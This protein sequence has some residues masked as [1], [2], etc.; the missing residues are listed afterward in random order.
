MVPGLAGK[1][2]EVAVAAAGPV[3]SSAEAVRLGREDL[4]T[5]E[6]LAALV[7][8]L[9]LM[10]TLRSAALAL[11]PMAIGVVSVSATLGVLGALTSVMPVSVFAVNVAA[12]LGF[13]LSVDY[14]LL[15]MMRCREE[16]AGGT[17]VGEAV[18]RSVRSAGRAVLFSAAT[19]VARMAALLIFPVPFLRSLA[20]GGIAVVVFSALTTVLIYPVLLRFSL[21][22]A[23]RLDRWLFD[24]VRTLRPGREPS[25]RPAKGPAVPGALA[26]QS[27]CCSALLLW[28]GPGS[29][30]PTNVS[31]PRPRWCARPLSECAGSFRRPSGPK[32]P[33]CSA[34]PICS[35]RM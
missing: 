20:T 29:A 6:I 16:M 28:T 12:A 7:V 8:L 23:S 4:R 24:R 21:L 34:W 3:W 5:A 13:G 31:C 32:S 15:V 14:G 22:P 19:V 30:L 18:A 27:S 9:I 35:L 33:L 11:L 2:G 1:R 10:V 26:R 25:V 17:E